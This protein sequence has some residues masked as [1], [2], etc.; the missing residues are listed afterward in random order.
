M[1]SLQETLL[2]IGPLLVKRIFSNYDLA[3]TA[4]RLMIHDDEHWLA[5]WGGRVSGILYGL[6][7]ALS[8]LPVLARIVLCIAWSLAVL[9]A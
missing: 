3:F 2:T 8:W 9:S 6:E 4:E 1:F 5:H 7:R